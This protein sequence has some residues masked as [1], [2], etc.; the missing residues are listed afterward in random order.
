MGLQRVRH[1]WVYTHTPKVTV[2]LN[3]E[4]IKDFSISRETIGIFLDVA[5][6]V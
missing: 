5:F 1:D 2:E 4:K 6:G 3:S